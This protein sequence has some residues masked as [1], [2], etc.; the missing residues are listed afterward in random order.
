MKTI[1]I[2]LNSNSL[3]DTI[4]IMPCVEY[5]MSKNNDNTCV[6]CWND[7]VFVFDP[8]DWNW[9]PVYKGTK[10]Q[11]VCQRSITPLQVFQKLKI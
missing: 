10:K 11:H 3:G 8:G 1:L 5:F 4:A 7:E 2:Q 9:C 6:F